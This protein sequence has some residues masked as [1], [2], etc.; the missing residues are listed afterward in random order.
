MRALLG[1]PT[2]SKENAKVRKRRNAVKRPKGED[3]KRVSMDVHTLSVFQVS[4]EP[5]GIRQGVE[6]EPRGQGHSLGV[7]CVPRQRAAP[8]WAAHRPGIGA[9][10]GVGGA[11]AGAGAAQEAGPVI[12]Y[13]AGARP[14]WPRLW[15]RTPGE[16]A[17]PEPAGGHCVAAGGCPRTA[18][19]QGPARHR[20]EAGLGVE[21]G[22]RGH[23]PSC[24]SAPVCAASLFGLL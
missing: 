5:D 10:R 21:P 4:T 19:R 22:A 15:K 20:E 18:G 16:E 1:P 13:R 11:G 8:G 9:A 7:A 6:R 3:K 24:P 2:F 23:A 14:S 17:A 12:G